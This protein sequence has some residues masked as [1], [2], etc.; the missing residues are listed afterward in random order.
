M[1]PVKLLVDAADARIRSH[2][3]ETPLEPSPV[4]SGLSGATVYLKLE[5]LQ[6]TGSF[7]VRGAFNRLLSLTPQERARGVVA[8]SSGN[9]G[10]AV[11][12]GMSTIGI[13]GVIFVPES[14][15]RAKV[16]KI[17]Q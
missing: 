7:K 9:H 10:A 6:R 5:N 12:L 4:L 17:R 11:A 3:R 13:A 16:D 2:V 14:A 1:I 15:S 8:A